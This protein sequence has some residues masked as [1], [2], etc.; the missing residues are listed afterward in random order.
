M[1]GSIES[2]LEALAI[3]LPPAPIPVANYVPAVIAGPLLFISGQLPRDADGTLITGRLGAELTIE[4]GQAAARLAA[5]NILAQAQAALGT[6]DRVVQVVRLNGFVNAGAGFA[7]H[8]KVI[9]G[10]SDVFVEVLGD[11]GRH[12]RAAVGAAS[13]PANAAV[14]IDAIFSIQI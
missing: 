14:E 8:P 6:L 11:A 1:G 3:T 10:A 2:R 4:R 7:D 13:L 9:N 12:T 5:L